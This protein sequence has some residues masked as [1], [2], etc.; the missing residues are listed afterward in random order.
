[1]RPSPP[2]RT[3][4]TVPAPA[5]RVTEIAI[6][7]HAYLQPPGGWCLNNAGIL[8]SGGQ[9]ALVDTAATETRAR[10]L[11]AAA[12]ELN[13]APPRTVVTTHFHGDHAFGN[14]VF[15]EALVIGHER[16]RTEM[17][18]AGLHLKSLWPHV[19][20]GDIE[21]APPTVTY[22]DRLTLH[23]GEIRA[24]LDHVGPAHTSNDTV[25]WL[26]AQKVLFTGDLA[27]N[28]V[29]PFFLMGSL[30]GSLAA[31][32]RLRAYGATTVVPG[33]GAVCGPE[34]FDAVEGYLLLVRRL[35]QE[36]VRAGRTP[37]QTA[38]GAH[39]GR[40]AHLLDP[41]RLSANLSRAYAELQ[42]LPADAPL[43]LPQK[44]A[45]LDEMTEFN[46]GPLC[47]LA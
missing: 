14:F 3:P 9:S 31:I 47:C 20:W 37:L 17:T 19:R 21:L 24:E 44:H 39:L 41:E 2:V 1:M 43:P 42:G 11:R 12:L 22:R 46:G 38:R 34:V 10:S 33:H 32:E 8:V 27:M 35:A 4:V 16:T 45:A 7:V 29:T 30:A 6:G 13:P 23:V 5:G 25:V 28:G 40:Y 26:P 36:G 18:A 15:P